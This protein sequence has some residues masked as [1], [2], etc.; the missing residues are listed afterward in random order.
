MLPHGYLPLSFKDV[1]VS[2]IIRC[3]HVVAFSSQFFLPLN[4]HGR[5]RFFMPNFDRSD[6]GNPGLPCIGGII[7]DNAGKPIISSLGPT[8]VCSVH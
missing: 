3:W 8:G 5:L 4:L 2:R 7:R 1:G 6:I